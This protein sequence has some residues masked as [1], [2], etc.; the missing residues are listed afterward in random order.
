MTLRTRSPLVKPFTRRSLLSG[1]LAASFVSCRKKLIIPDTLFPTGV[2]AGDASADAVLLSTLYRGERPL[3]L[4]VYKGSEVIDSRVVPTSDAGFAEVLIEGLLDDTR[5][6][7][8][9]S[10]EP[11]DSARSSVR[12]RFRT[13]HPKAAQE[14]V[15]LGAVSCLRQTNPM[16]VMDRVAALDDLH[17]FLLLGDTVYVDGADTLEEYREKWHEGFTR[18]PHIAARA[19]QNVI[20]TWDDHEILN[21]ANTELPS[22]SQLR[23]A[24]TSF[25][26]RVPTRRE[27][28]DRIWRSVRFGK[29]VEV[30]VL[31]CRGE[32]RPSAHEFISRAQLNWL[33][34]RL[35]DSDAM[36]KVIMSSVPMGQFVGALWA[37]FAPDRWEGYPH[38][39]EELLS[40]IEDHHIPGVLWVSG[41]FHLGL[42]GRLALQ[43]L[44]SRALEV[45]V[46]PGS[47]D[48]NPSPIYPSG[49]QWDFT[50]GFNT[51][52]TLAFDVAE[53]TV[54][55]DFRDASDRVLFKKRYPLGP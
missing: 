3:Q 18:P 9:F 10:E 50:T 55:I 24:R 7:Y 13:T 29:T 26:E 1:A 30:L 22:A 27:A 35:A 28:P 48:R 53:Y 15:L 41:D 6:E 11:D 2:T 49:P 54:E 45:L 42:I 16:P 46:G 4:A 51:Y 32:R 33:K 40:F 31:D 38:Q 23:E 5:Y 12:G 39:R 25:Y 43:G 44:G 21:D 37:A 34:S 20:A 19:T 14:N 52:S 36:F 47:S 8:V 17:A